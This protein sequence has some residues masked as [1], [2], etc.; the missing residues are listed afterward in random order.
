RYRATEANGNGSYSVLLMYTIIE[1][2]FS[3]RRR[4][5]RS[6][7]DWSSDVC[8]SDLITLYLVPIFSNHLSLLFAK[9]KDYLTHLQKSLPY[10]TRQ[11]ALHYFLPY[12]V[13][14]SDLQKN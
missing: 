9:M 10:E 1:F 12:Y 13:L 6:K 11:K 7:R 8:S 5:T 14:L 2:F 3:S 4:H